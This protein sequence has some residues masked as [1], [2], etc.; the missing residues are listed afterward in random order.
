MPGRRPVA[1]ST[2]L[3]VLV[4]DTFTHSRFDP[5][6]QTTGLCEYAYAFLCSTTLSGDN[7]N[8]LAR[9]KLGRV[10]EVPSCALARPVSSRP[11]ANRTGESTT[12]DFITSTVITTKNAVTKQSHMHS[13]LHWIVIQLLLCSCCT[14]V[15]NVDVTDCNVWY[16]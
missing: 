16:V 13:D 9:R 11:G 4:I 1:K 14:V 15:V 10:N 3:H 12:W 2:V 6:G 8:L 7:R 5:A